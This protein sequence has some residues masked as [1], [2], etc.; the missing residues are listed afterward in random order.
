MLHDWGYLVPET[1]VNQTFE[2]FCFK[3]ADK[4]VDVYTVTATKLN[5]SDQEDEKYK[6]LIV[7]ISNKS[8]IDTDTL[9]RFLKVMDDNSLFHGI[10]VIKESMT[11][12]V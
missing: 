11:S 1:I 7:F 3:A 8:K 12:T 6:G 10:I 9:N 4:L 5:L 2:E